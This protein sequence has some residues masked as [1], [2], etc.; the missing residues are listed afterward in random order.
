MKWNVA[1]QS[2]HGT[3]NSPFSRPSLSIP[4][5]ETNHWQ[6]LNQAIPQFRYIHLSVS[7]SIFHVIISPLLSQYHRLL[8]EGE[9]HYLCQ[10]VIRDYP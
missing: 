9:A 8:R 6:M 3:L 7:I 10:G 1:H 4:E 5:W 2:S